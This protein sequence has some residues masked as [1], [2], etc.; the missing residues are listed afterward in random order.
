M[1]RENILTRQSGIINSDWIRS[2]QITIVG[3]G[4]IGSHLALA[5]ARMGA[6]NLKLIDPDVVSIENVNS[7]GFDMID[8]GKH[9]VDAVKQKIIRAVGIMPTTDKRYITSASSLN[10]LND[11]SV[12]V[13]AVDN[14]ESRKVIADLIEKTGADL[15]LI[16]PAMGAE[17]I[18]IDVY[19]TDYY[20]R[21]LA[22]FRE[23]WFSDEDG[24]QEDCTSKATI[25]TTLLI[26][27][28]ICKII[29]DRVMSNSYMRQLTFNVKD[30]AIMSMFSSEDESLT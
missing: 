15:L 12:I 22:K 16:N 24:V 18:T 23:A 17:Y 2:K 4:G 27:G 21:G 10:F 1:S 13:L 8:V 6:E 29:K 20:S 11:G 19:K 7:Q 14:M 26:S 5:L 30:N 9:K 28:F 3:C 25:Y